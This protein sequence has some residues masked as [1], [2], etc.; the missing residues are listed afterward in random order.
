MSDTASF[1]LVYVIQL[2][3]KHLWYIGIV[4]GVSALLAIVFT[5]P[6]IYKPQFQS[7]TI[8]YPTNAERYDVLNLFA[9][10]PSVFMYGT[11]KEVEKLL[12]TANSEEASM[13]VIDSLNL[14][15]A[16]G[17]DKDNGV[18]PKFYALEQYNG[19]VSAIK[20]SGHGLKIEAYDT[21][22]ERAAAIVNVLVGY[23]DRMTKNRMNKQKD[24][25]LSLYK[26]SY[27]EMVTEQQ[28]YVDSAKRIRERYNIFEYA[29]Q[30][31]VLVGEVLRTEGE[32]AKEK[33]RGNS[34]AANGLRAKL[35]ALTGKDPE[36]AIN[37]DNFGEGLD[38]LITLE[39]IYTRLTV[40]IKQMRTKIDELEMMKQNDYSSIWVLEKAMPSDKKARPIR[41]LILAAALMLSTLVSVL[42]VV[43]V[44]R[45]PKL[46]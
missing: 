16:Y 44:D 38:Q 36:S 34:A 19:N 41:W 2:V 17:V 21:E 20:A 26:R 25:L 35:N 22:P 30:T 12:A 31:E 7:S 27:D 3:R 37:L 46:W 40:D 14:W 11:S 29:R 13:F 6:A 33:A 23:V 4:V 8:I 24:V 42:G 1:N 32:L 15:D 10:E 28:A 18:S 43:V 5:M 9:E 39:Q 45:M